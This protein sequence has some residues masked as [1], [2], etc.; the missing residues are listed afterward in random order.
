[1]QQSENMENREELLPWIFS[2]VVE[3]KNVKDFGVEKIVGESVV[4]RNGR[5]GNC[6]MWKIK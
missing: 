6:E 3:K 5:V 2:R 1:M 4:E